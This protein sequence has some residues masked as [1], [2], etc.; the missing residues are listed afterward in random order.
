MTGRC[1]ASNN[2]FEVLQIVDGRHSVCPDLCVLNFDL[3]CPQHL[4]TLGWCR[5]NH[6]NG[7]PGRRTF[8]LGFEW[9]SRYFETDS[10]AGSISPVN[11]FEIMV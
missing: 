7:G 3:Y 6:W 11:L 9:T 1:A 8:D 4:E 10:A 5:P 2:S